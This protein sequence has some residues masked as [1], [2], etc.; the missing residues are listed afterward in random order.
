MLTY[1][2]ISI[3]ICSICPFLSATW[4]FT[5][6]FWVSFEG[7]HIIL[8]TVCCWIFDPRV[9]G[10]LLGLYMLYV[11]TVFAL[12]SLLFRNLFLC[13]TRTQTVPIWFDLRLNEFLIC[14]FNQS[15]TEIYKVI[16]LLKEHN[17]VAFNGLGHIIEVKTKK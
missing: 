4:L 12:C 10:S 7:H 15:Y 11:Y 1:T 14:C 17:F 5:D 16:F 8:I 6:S 9:T 2:N 3:S 13:S